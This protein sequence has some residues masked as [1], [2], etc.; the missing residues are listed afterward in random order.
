PRVT[1]YSD[2]TEG[3]LFTAP[4]NSEGLPNRR[5]VWI[6]DGVLRNLVYDRFWAWRSG[7]S[8][9]GFPSGYAMRGGNSSIDEMI[10][11]TE[12]GLL[13]TRFWYMRPVDPRTVLYTGLTRDGTFL[14]ENG[15][16]AGAVKNLRWNESPALLLRELEG[17]G[18]PVRVSPSESG[19]LGPAVR[20][21][22]IK[23]RGFTFSSISDAI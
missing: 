5:M 19:D 22:P 23:A 11:S 8:P 12:R 20:V 15:R 21:P 3:E 16:I 13:V 17:I 9:T 1:I 4:F 7:V 14:V 18:A 2:P 6:E 10:A